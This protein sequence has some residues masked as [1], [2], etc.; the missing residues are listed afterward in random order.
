MREVDRQEVQ[1]KLDELLD[2]VGHGDRILVTSS[3]VPI[4][5]IQPPERTRMTRE[6]VAATI[7]TLKELRKDTFL[8]PDLTIEELIEEGR[9]Y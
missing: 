7:A 3:G 9:R 6:E 4:A 2:E 1:E 8:G 5:V